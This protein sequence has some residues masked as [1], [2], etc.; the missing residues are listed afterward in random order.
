MSRSNDLEKRIEK[1]EGFFGSLEKGI[2]DKLYQTF[3]RVQDFSY[4]NLT[5]KVL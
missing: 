3:M 4:N 1:L 5:E 2:T